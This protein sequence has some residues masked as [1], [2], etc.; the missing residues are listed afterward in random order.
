MT[1]FRFCD[2]WEKVPAGA[3]PLAI[4]W[5]D[6]GWW[7][8]SPTPGHH[9]LYESAVSRDMLPPLATTQ[10]TPVEPPSPGYGASPAPT[11]RFLAPVLYSDP[12]VPA[13]LSAPHLAAPASTSVGV[14]V[15]Q[16]QSATSRETATQPPA[17]IEVCGAGSVE[18]NGLYVLS[19]QLHN[20]H[21]M[22]RKVG[23]PD[24]TIIFDDGGWWIGDVQAAR[25]DFYQT[26]EVDTPLPPLGPEAWTPVTPDASRA[27][28]GPPPT[29]TIVPDIG[30]STPLTT[31]T[32]AITAGATSTA[33]AVT[34]AVQGAAE[35][36]RVAVESAPP[37]VQEALV[38]AE[39]A[40]EKAKTTVR[41]VTERD[42]LPALA[43]SGAVVRQATETGIEHLQSFTDR[44]I[45][46]AVADSA[47][48]GRDL[49]ARG[50]DV[51]NPMAMQVV[52]TAQNVVAAFSDAASY[53]CERTDELVAS[54]QPANRDA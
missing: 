2:R 37:S 54:T 40:V 1:V 22:W 14:S 43:E 31:A 48:T 11:L 15:P 25:R 3:E 27:G 33:A 29:L 35:A 7:I 5:D 6:G 39:T 20:N 17:R 52:V 51:L 18:S 50:Q 28:V 16:Q 8:G 41:T 24:I 34:A 23:D 12:A 10:W 53:A 46:P 30:S 4:L 9:D 21:S 32:A 26:A 47:C 38:G 49:A 42:V 45:I 44:V 13:T 36:V 19:G